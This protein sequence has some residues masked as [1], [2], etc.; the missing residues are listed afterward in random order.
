MPSLLAGL[1]FENSG[2]VFS[3]GISSGFIK[4][5]VTGELVSPGGDSRLLIRL[6]NDNNENSYRSFINMNGDSGGGEWETTG[7]HTGRT[8]WS[9][10]ANFTAEYTFAVNPCA[11]KIAGNGNS[12]FALGNGKIL[13]YECHGYFSTTQHLNA[14]SLIFTGG[15]A[16]GIAK[17]YHM[18]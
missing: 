3:P 14:I 9:L 11:N 15:K 10:D 12:V 16:T 2:L 6:N 13:G 1:S 17:F 18:E 4:V 8:G 5:L 7:F